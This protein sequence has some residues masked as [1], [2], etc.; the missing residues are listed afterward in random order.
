[1]VPGVSRASPSRTRS[2]GVEA[3]VDALPNSAVLDQGGGA[4]RVAA[5]AAR[6]RRSARAA[7]A[8]VTDRRP[9]R[10]RIATPGASPRLTAAPGCAPPPWSKRFGCVD[11]RSSTS[12][13]ACSR[14]G[15]VAVHDGRCGARLV[16]RARTK[17]LR[18][19]LDPPRPGGHI[20]AN[21]SVTGCSPLARMH[22]PDRSV[23]LLRP[24]PG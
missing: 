23:R 14:L 19:P 11:A 24:T 1:M 4:A 16:D 6:L 15:I 5:P 20:R 7:W 18:S 17:G 8:P 2:A 21:L 13:R 10:P 9:G 3:R 22:P 12:T